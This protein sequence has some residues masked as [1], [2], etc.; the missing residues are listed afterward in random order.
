MPWRI[1][2]LPS[3]AALPQ[4]QAAKI[5]RPYPHTSSQLMR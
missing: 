2:L 3:E 5:R 1:R 4:K